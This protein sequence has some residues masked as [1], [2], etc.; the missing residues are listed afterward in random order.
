MEIKISIYFSLAKVIIMKLRHKDR[1]YGFRWAAFWANVSKEIEEG[2][3]QES[4]NIKYL[5]DRDYHKIKKNPVECY[6]E[7][8]LE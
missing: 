8:F 3:E 6:P 5:S 7:L 4:A 1:R 2:R